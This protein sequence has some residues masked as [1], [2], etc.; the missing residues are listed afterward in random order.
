MTDDTTIEVDA[1]GMACPLPVI[2]L[3]RVV[4]DVTIG[5]HVRL[6]ADDAAARV[7][8]PVWCRMQQ[9]RLVDLQEEDDVLVFLVEKTSELRRSGGAGVS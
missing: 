8:V 3:A 2:E 6:L 9:Q 7:D 1:V 4:G 5:T